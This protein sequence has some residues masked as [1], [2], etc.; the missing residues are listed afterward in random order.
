MPAVP[1]ASATASSTA[2][3][4]ASIVHRRGMAARVERIMPVP[5]SLPTMTTA[6]IATI[7]WPR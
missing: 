4:A 5:Y 2:A 6:S 3:L 1:A 7:A